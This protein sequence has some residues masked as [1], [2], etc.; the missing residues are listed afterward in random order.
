MTPHY[1]GCTMGYA[2]AARNPVRDRRMISVV[3]RVRSSS[4][5][6]PTAFNECLAVALQHR[7]SGRATHMAMLHSDIA[8]E[9][10]WLDTLWGEM[11]YE[12][13]DLV[14][15]IVPIKNDMGLTST[16]VGVEGDRWKVNR[17]IT[18]E[19]AKQLPETFGPERVCGAGE[20]LLVNTGCWL[21][22]MRRPWWDGFAFNL[23]SR[24][25]SP[26]PGCYAVETR[27]EDWEMSHV[28]HEHKARVI[29]TR[30]VRLKHEG[31][32]SWPNY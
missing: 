27:S 26:A 12:G 3:D 21:A 1:G 24:I 20:V 6:L 5:L 14:S 7:D 13:A 16:A 22:D 11:W 30:K 23:H 32:H 17:L 15:A 9:P 2:V 29:V 18:L 8:A 10:A 28:L 25:T 19:Q 4:S 31:Y